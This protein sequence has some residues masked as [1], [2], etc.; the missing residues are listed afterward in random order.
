MGFGLLPV[1]RERGL[2]TALVHFG[3]RE[4]S[5]LG[6]DMVARLT[7]VDNNRAINVFKRS[8]FVVQS[9]ENCGIIIMVCRLF[10]VPRAKE[11]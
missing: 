1:Y 3:C 9:E 8:G 2:G 7:P 4:V 10:A 11:L 6:I 5:R